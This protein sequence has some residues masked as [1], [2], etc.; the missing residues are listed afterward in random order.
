MQRLKCRPFLPESDGGCQA[1]SRLS[2]A[3]MA[4]A[5]PAPVTCGLRCSCKVST[6]QC[7]LLEQFGRISLYVTE[8]TI[9]KHYV[10]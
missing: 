8:D 1:K 6:V 2:T 7:T 4:R 5:P 9:E 3:D 10:T